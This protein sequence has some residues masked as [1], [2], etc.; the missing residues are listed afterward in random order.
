[1][2]QPYI[3]NTQ[4]FTCP[5]DSG[6]KKPDGSILGTGKYIPYTQLAGS[7][8]THY[9]SL[10]MNCANW[11]D[12]NIQDRGPGNWTNQDSQGRTQG[13]PISQLNSPATTAYI[14][15]GD[16][17]YQFDWDFNQDAVV[18]KDSGYPAFGW[19]G[20]NMGNGTEGG[21]VFRHGGPDIAN[22]IWC[23]G[24]VKPLNMGQATVKNSAGMYY[25]F[26]NQGQ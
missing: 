5:D 3:K 13:T 8:T 15:D 9:G 26:T 7:D 16:G 4:V 1:M 11:N 20:G 6:T 14:A 24:H 25:L 22:V 10:A 17:S 2:V 12:P 18:G 19:N 23:D 21:L